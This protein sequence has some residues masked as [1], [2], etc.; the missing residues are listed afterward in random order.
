[1]PL[2]VNNNRTVNF[3]LRLPVPHIEKIKIY[4]EYMEVQISVYVEANL[5]EEETDL[6]E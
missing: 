3:G 2:N 6:Y 1:M 4:D 5:G